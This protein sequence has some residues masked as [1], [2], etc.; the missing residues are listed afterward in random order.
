VTSIGGQALDVVLGD[1]PRV[2]GATV[3][4]EQEVGNGRVFIVDGLL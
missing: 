3:L 2:N 1:R 4:G